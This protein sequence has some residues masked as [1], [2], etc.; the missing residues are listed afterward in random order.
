MRSKIVMEA[1]EKQTDCFYFK[2][3]LGDLKGGFREDISDI[4]ILESIVKT[5]INRIQSNCITIQFER[6]SQN[7]IVLTA[8]LKEG[9]LNLYSYPK[10]NLLCIDGLSYKK[11]Y[12]PKLIIDTIAAILQ[13][14]QVQVHEIDRGEY[15]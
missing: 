10:R 8:I 12:N 2:H 4:N 3:V 7:G 1:I 15:N 14:N 6:V 5:S 11:T 9:R 13:A